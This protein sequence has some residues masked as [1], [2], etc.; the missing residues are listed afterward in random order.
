MEHKDTK[1]GTKQHRGREFWQLVLE[2]YSKSDQTVASVCRDKGL[3]Q[4]TF[5]GWRK[6]L[7]E[8]RQPMI[9]NL[10]RYW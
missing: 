7:R 5:Y 9:L 10:R 3:E 4:V 6:R 8:L 1:K 2:A